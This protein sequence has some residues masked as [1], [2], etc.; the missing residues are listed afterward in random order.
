[1]LN[2][3]HGADGIVKFADL[4]GGPF[5]QDDLHAVIMVQ[6]DMLGRDDDL[7]MMVLDL[8][9]IVHQLALMMIIDE[10]DGACNDLIL[11]PLFFDQGFPHE[12]S[13]CLR[14]VL[15]IPLRDEFIEFGQEIALN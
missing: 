2:A 3:P 10:G 6:M 11:H 12:V 9:Q 1:M 13:Q 5:G 14:T 4:F 15:I 7:M 8:H